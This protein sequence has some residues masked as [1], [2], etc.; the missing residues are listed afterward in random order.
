[1]SQ[2]S[3]YLYLLTLSTGKFHIQITASKKEKANEP[4]TGSLML[5]NFLLSLLGHW[6]EGVSWDWFT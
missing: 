4:H 6:P 5:F 2:D 1:M 3:G